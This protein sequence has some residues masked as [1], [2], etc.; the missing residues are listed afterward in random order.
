M[1]QQ[2]PLADW[3]G[4][5]V[6]YDGILHHWKQL[7]NGQTA[8][9]IKTVRV[10]R[11]DD[12]PSQIRSFDH[13]WFYFKEPPTTRKLERLDKFCGVGDIIQYCR[14]N[15]TID[16]AIAAVPAM[17][18]FKALEGLHDAAVRRFEVATLVSVLQQSLDCMQQRIGFLALEVDHDEWKNWINVELCL[19]KERQEALSQHAI[20]NLSYEIRSRQNQRPKPNPD[21]LPFGKRRRR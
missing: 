21:I 15:G 3:L 12:P 7:E 6:L 13:L 9:L 1:G 8:Y 19:W 10:R 14:R 4:E 2:R 20:L 17:S 5:R 18:I 11:Y 16:Y